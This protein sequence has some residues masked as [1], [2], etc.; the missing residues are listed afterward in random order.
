G[1][2]KV[3]TAGYCDGGTLLATTLAYL[4]EKR[5][6]RVTS[7]TFFAA[8]VDFTH[9][10]DLLVFVDEDQIS[11][12]ERDMEESGVLEGSRMAMAFNMLRSNDL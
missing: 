12:L 2:M 1:E 10:G 6:Q 5:Q 3:H 4:A 9:A 7:A 8:Q 11:A